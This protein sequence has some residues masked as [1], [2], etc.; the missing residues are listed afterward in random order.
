MAE[1]ST[2]L[3]RFVHHRLRQLPAP[4]AP[5]T[6]LPRVLAAVREWSERPW[7]QRAW[8]TWPLTWQ[9]ASASALVLFVAMGAALLPSAQTAASGAVSN[10]AGRAI[11]TVGVKVSQIEDAIRA[12]RILWAIVVQPLVTYA[13]AIVAVMWIAA[14]ALGLALNRMM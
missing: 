7:Y 2:D 10:V 13:F 9:I 12:T 8:P 6:L 11:A 1:H 14:A 4:R 3:E 5:G